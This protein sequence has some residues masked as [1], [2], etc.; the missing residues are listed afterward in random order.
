MQI[1]GYATGCECA[2]T[3]KTEKFSIR[4]E[5]AVKFAKLWERHKWLKTVV[6]CN[7]M[8]WNPKKN[9]DKSVRCWKDTIFERLRRVEYFQSV[10]LLISLDETIYQKVAR[11]LLR[12]LIYA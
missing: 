3:L 4:S 2:E 9:Y 1:P 7:I 10:L 11:R 12:N 6:D 8:G 5:V